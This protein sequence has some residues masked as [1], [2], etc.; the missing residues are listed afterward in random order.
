[1]NEPDLIALHYMQLMLSAN[2]LPLYNPYIIY[3][4]FILSTYIDTSSTIQPSNMLQPAKRDVTTC[5]AVRDEISPG[6]RW[7]CQVSDWAVVD[8]ILTSA[9]TL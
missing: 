9:T 3:N 8:E 7:S 4:Y 5:I 1:M 6:P 2:I